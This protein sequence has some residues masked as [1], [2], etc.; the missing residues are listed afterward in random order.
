[1]VERER[2]RERNVYRLFVEN[3]E[4]NRPLER[5][6]CRW[7]IIIKWILKKK[8]RVGRCGMDSSGSG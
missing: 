3:S 8:N 5:P 7:E 4:G 1:M 2:E 6:R